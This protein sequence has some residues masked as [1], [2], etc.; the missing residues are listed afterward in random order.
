MK[1]E[2]FKFLEIFISNWMFKK[3]QVPVEYCPLDFE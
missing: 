2:T 1:K 3:I